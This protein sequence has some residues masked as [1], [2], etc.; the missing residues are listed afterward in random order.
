MTALEEIH[1][2]DNQAVA[3]C[4]YITTTWVD[5]LIARFPIEMWSHYDNIHG[6]R[7]TNHLE[8]WHNKM[9]KELGRPHPNIFRAI[10]LFKE[11]QNET[12][13]KLR[14]LRA[15][16]PAPTQRR[17]YRLITERLVRLKRR[18]QNGQI[19]PYQYAGAVGGI[20]SFNF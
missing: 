17:K 9:K 13:N 7:T 15:G 5:P 10:E 8:S 18:L 19:A 20:L 6:V 11:Q 1:N 3:F 2:E 16:G 14:L 12:E 4:D